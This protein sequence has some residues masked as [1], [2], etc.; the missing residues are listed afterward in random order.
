MKI[1]LI[2][3]AETPDQSN[4]PPSSDRPDGLGE[5]SEGEW[6][7]FSAGQ[8]AREDAR[9]SEVELRGLLEEE[10]LVAGESVTP[11]QSLQY[12][13]ATGKFGLPVVVYYDW[14]RPEPGVGLSGGPIIQGIQVMAD[15]E[16]GAASLWLDVD[17]NR[18][19]VDRLTQLIVRDEQ[20]PKF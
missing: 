17:A 12:R 10:G 8:A 11:G 9:I 5:W 3:Y 20:P 4:P 6:S 14:R 19:E 2:R 15:E 13:S 7:E 1:R 16:P 18:S